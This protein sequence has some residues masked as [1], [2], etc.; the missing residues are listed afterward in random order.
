MGGSDNT[1]DGLA[2]EPRRYRVPGQPLLNWHQVEGVSRS[3]DGLFVQGKEGEPTRGRPAVRGKGTTRGPQPTP[4]THPQPTQ[5][6]PGP[7]HPTHGPPGRPS[8]PLH[9]HFAQQ[10]QW[11]LRRPSDP[12]GGWTGKSDFQW[13]SRAPE[14]LRAM[15]SARREWGTQR[16]NP[17][18]PAAQSLCLPVPRGPSTQWATSGAPLLLV[19]FLRSGPLRHRAVVRLRPGY[20]VPSEPPLGPL[21][22]PVERIGGPGKGRNLRQNRGGQNQGQRCGHSAA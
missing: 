8:V 22:H 21:R 2:S 14:E 10:E 16:A 19:S 9:H 20:P 17:G 13:A 6:R 1:G 12:T 4:H 5:G 15:V 18:A 3:P 7:P 11:S